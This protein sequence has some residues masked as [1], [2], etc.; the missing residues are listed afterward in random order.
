[1]RA[2]SEDLRAKALDAV[3]RGTPRKE[4]ARIFGISLPSIKRWLRRRRETGQVGAKAPS[5][6]PPIKGAM[7][8]E[9][10]P[11][12]LRSNPDLTLEEHC[13]AFE[14]EFGMKVSTATV[15]RRISGL[16]GGGWPLKKS[17]G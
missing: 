3:D 5:G 11:G 15:S 4:V 14:E 9:W 2:Y 10:L 7:L 16:P 13:E 12:H 17:L 8:E 6:P 1:M